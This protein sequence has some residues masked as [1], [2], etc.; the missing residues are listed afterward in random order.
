M[1]VGDLSCAGNL[2]LGGRWTLAEGAIVTNLTVSIGGDFTLS[3]AARCG[4]YANT[5]NGAIT[6]PNLYAA[7]A[8][9]DVAGDFTIA[10]TAILYPTADRLT[11]TAVRFTCADFALAQGAT[12]DAKNRGWGW[13]TYTAAAQIDPRRSKY[14][15]YNSI[16]RFGLA[17][18]AMDVGSWGGGASYACPYIY[19]PFGPGTQSGAYQTP[20]DGGGVFWLRASGT[21][22]VNGK[23]LVDAPH[24]RY[25][26][27]SGGGIWI[28]AGRFTAGTTALLSSTGGNNSHGSGVG[29]SGGAISIAIGVPDAQLDALA[30]GASPDSLG[31]D[32]IDDILVANY[33]VR[34]GYSWTDANNIEVYGASG[35]ATTVYGE[36]SDISVIIESASQEIGSP[37]PAYGAHSLASN[38]EQT[39]SCVGYG[40]DLANPRNVRYVCVGYAVSNSTAE[41]ASGVTDT[42]T[43][44]VGSR[45]LTVSWI[46]GGREV[47][48]PV[49]VPANATVRVNGTSF[50][51]D[52]PVWLPEAVA[53]VFEVVPE[54]GYEFLCWE[55]EVP[56]GLAKA[57]PITLPAGTP[58][59]IRPVVREIQTATSRVWKGGTGVWTNPA[60]W[61]PA[62]IPGFADNV[63][64][65]SGTCLVSNYFECASLAL[66]GA[67][68]FKV[69]TSA[70]KNL[71]EADLV[72]HGDLSMTNTATLDI[73]ATSDY[74]F[75]RLSVGGDLAL[76]GANTLTVCAG[77]ISETRT[78]ATGAGFVTVGGDFSVLGTAKVTPVSAP[79]TGGSVIFKVGGLFT[80]GQGAQFY[81]PGKGY[82]RV[83]G[84]VPICL[85]PG[86]GNSYTV[87]GGYGGTGWGQNATYG[88]TYGFAN[89]PIHPG[90][91]KEAYNNNKPGGGL[92]RVHAV[93]VKFSGTVNAMAYESS[94]SFGGPSGGGVWITSAGKIS[95]GDGAS[96][97]VKGGFGTNYTSEGGGGRI[98][99]GA[100]LSDDDIAELAETGEL[101][102][103]P[104]K[105]IIGY[106][107]FTNKYPSVSIDISCGR[108]TVVPPHAGT[109]RFL[110]ARRKGTMVLMR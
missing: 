85:S 101:A 30:A 29:G 51:E 78:F 83:D 53:A 71:E 86:L 14:G 8:R 11:G 68:K 96:V 54:S 34:G 109:F 5:M 26:A 15:T 67:A 105:N 94:T 102:R 87:G 106:D 103:L 17:P 52:A 76:F 107:A 25:S 33:T 69:G 13:I 73:S 9:V 45:A 77:P 23:I 66:S 99:F 91:P 7:A 21:A 50:A 6:W 56:E 31:L 18:N 70:T 43:L 35:K 2:V 42:F 93:R 81:C 89:A 59:A 4:V 55:G 12:V 28:A 97:T 104:A 100:G 61:E 60:K 10:D 65:A 46:W 62:G 90:A 64:V 47:R 3:G 84:H 20:S 92:V 39:F 108:N 24:G 36:T 16:N 32:H 19:A 95:F 49:S 1:V 79:Y 41:V 72:V 74:R 44:D 98:A 22:S 110:D 27:P 40:Y 48:F 37:D 88:N 38:S 80:L 57:N 82:A 58:R 63:S 75:G